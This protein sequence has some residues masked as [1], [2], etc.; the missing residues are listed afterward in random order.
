MIVIDGREYSDDLSF[1]GLVVLALAVLLLFVL[2]FY[3]Y[4]SPPD[5]LAR[6]KPVVVLA[7][8]GGFIVLITLA[9]FLQN[10]G[11][12]FKV[13]L[14]FME[15]RLQI[16]PIFSLAPKLVPYEDI[17]ELELWFG[18]P[19]RRAARGCSI[20]SAKYG[21]VT[22]VETFPSR[23]RLKA[24]AEAVRPFLEKRG[25]RMKMAEEDA[26]SLRVVFLRDV[27]KKLSF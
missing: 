13:P 15:E 9:L 14:R 21:S 22:S 27:R 20:L 8:I 3:L 6:A 19:Y 23:E 18:L 12:L 26:H 2:P 11:M 25:L 5:F 1:G 4:V 17:S 10:R 7:G 24:F 16:Q